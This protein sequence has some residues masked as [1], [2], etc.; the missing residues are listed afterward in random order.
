MEFRDL[1]GRGSLYPRAVWP[2]DIIFNGRNDRTHSRRP[3]SGHKSLPYGILRKYWQCNWYDVTELVRTRSSYLCNDSVNIRAYTAMKGTRYTI[4]F[5]QDQPR[6]KTKFARLGR[7]RWYEGQAATYESPVSYIEY[8]WTTIGWVPALLMLIQHQHV[9]EAHCARRKFV[10]ESGRTITQRHAVLVRPPRPCSLNNER[11]HTGPRYI[12]APPFFWKLA[13]RRRC[14][15]R[16][17]DTIR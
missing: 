4:Q 7:G 17:S 9:S 2:L 6:A 13:Y 8:C 14:R 11:P 16:R 10:L 1:L 12:A 5:A 15:G 3:H